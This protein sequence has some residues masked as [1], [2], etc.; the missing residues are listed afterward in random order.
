M[1][2]PTLPAWY[3]PAICSRQAAADGQAFELR[4]EARPGDVLRV[5]LERHGRRGFDVVDPL[6]DV[7]HVLVERVERRLDQV[8]LAGLVFF[9]G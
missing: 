5:V 4:A 2:M 9:L 3:R 8:A 6:A 1:M 7:R